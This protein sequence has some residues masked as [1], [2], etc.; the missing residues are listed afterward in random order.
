MRYKRFNSERNNKY[1]IVLVLAAIVATCFAY[2]YFYSALLK[3]DFNPNKLIRVSGIKDNNELRQEFAVF[4]GKL[5]SLQGTTLKLQ[6]GDGNTLWQEEL[7]IQKP[8][9]A[10]LEEIIVA[11]DTEKGIITGVDGKGKIVWESAAKGRLVRMG[12]D[13]GYIWAITEY[14]RNTIVEILNINGE[15]TA[16][17]QLG[18]A[19]ALSVSLSPDGSYIALSTAEV[20][21]NRITGSIILYNDDSAIVWAKSYRDSLVMGVNITDEGFVHVLT[22]EMLTCLSLTGGIRWQQDVNG[23]I[24]KALLTDKGIT[25]MTLSEDYR[26]GIP[27]QKGQETVIYGKEGNKLGSLEHGQDIIGL[28]EGK[29]CIGIYSARRLQLADYNGKIVTDKE[30]DRDFVRVYLLEDNFM[31]HISAGKIYF[32]PYL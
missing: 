31:A 17:L 4:S 25:A 9:L 29:D 15:S 1:L 22:E 30:F 23:Y 28:V 26:S 11:A 8:L 3:T 12:A 19:E 20:K 16:Y 24:T 21:D 10:V 13:K 27:A 14:Q 7:D 18:E 6:S 2:P 5:A 32:E